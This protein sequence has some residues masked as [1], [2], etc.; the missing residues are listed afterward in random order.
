MINDAVRAQTI[1]IWATPF[2]VTS[3]LTI[4]ELTFDST[5][6]TLGFAV[7]GQT[8]TTGY[9]NVTISKTLVTKHCKS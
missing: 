1:T 3:K 9:I 4:T 2:S 7:S 8:G 5:N 6:K